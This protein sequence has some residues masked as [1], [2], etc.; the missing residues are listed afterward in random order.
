MRPLDVSLKDT[1]QSFFAE[2]LGTA[3]DL[4]DIPK[5]LFVLK[6]TAKIGLL[7]EGPHLYATDLLDAEEI[8]QGDVLIH[9]AVGQ[10]ARPYAE[11]LH[12]LFTQEFPKL[13]SNDFILHCGSGG[14]TCLFACPVLGL[15][16][17]GYEIE[18][19]EPVF[20]FYISRLFQR[21]NEGDLNCTPAQTKFFR[22]H[23]I[24]W[25]NDG[26]KFIKFKKISATGA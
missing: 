13:H 6:R 8:E 3:K 18:T 11:E 14:N 17:H 21:W 12:D 23:K 15:Y 2:I 1:E 4:K 10:M 20:R 25:Q 24:S 19:I 22:R 7:F 26:P 5:L 9:E 16:T